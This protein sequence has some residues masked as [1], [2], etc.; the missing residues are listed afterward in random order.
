[1]SAAASILKAE[2]L[3]TVAYAMICPA[4]LENMPSLT[5]DVYSFLW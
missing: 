1:M 4:E 5:R 2:M 3:E